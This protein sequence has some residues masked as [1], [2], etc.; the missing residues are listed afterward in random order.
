MGNCLSSIVKTEGFGG[1]YGGFNANFARVGTWNIIMFL[2][3]EQLQIFAR[4]RQSRH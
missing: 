1:L 3:L 4:D 2:S